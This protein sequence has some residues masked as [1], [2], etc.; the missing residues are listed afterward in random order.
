[1]PTTLPHRETKA[2]YATPAGGNAIPLRLVDDARDRRR[3][4]CREEPFIEPSLAWAVTG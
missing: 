1:M 3:A 2:D 4:A